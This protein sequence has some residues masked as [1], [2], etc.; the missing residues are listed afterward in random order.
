[1]PQVFVQG[2]LTSHFEAGEETMTGVV[3]GKP[4]AERI[5]R[6]GWEVLGVLANYRLLEYGVEGDFDEDDVLIWLKKRS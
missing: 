2:E 6:E 5:K 4:L 3:V 1:M